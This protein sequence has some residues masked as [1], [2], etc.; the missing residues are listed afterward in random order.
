MKNKEFTLVELLAV[1]II[2]SVL[3]LIIVSAILTYIKNGKDSYNENLKEELLIIAMIIYFT[4]FNR[5]TD[6]ITLE[7][8]SE[9]NDNDIT[10]NNIIIEENKNVKFLNFDVQKKLTNL[11]LVEIEIH[12]LYQNEIVFT[13]TLSIENF[14]ETIKLELEDFNYDINNIKFEY[15]VMQSSI[16]DDSTIPIKTG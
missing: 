7:N 6:T 2:I 10:I 12:L 1:I 16:Q 15:I 5:K 14:D 4:S 9:Q 8:I 11:S 13:D 3:S